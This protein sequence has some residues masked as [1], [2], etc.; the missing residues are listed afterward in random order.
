MSVS[1][2]LR[3]CIFCLQDR[4]GSQEHVFPRA[5]GGRLTIDRVCTSCNSMLGSRVDAALSDSFIVRSRRAQ[6]GLA[7]NSGEVPA[8]HE[9]LLG[10]S[11]LAD[12]PERRVQVAFNE[13]TGQLD[14]R[15][16]Y[17]ASDVVMPDGTKARQIIVDERDKD[18]IPKIIQRER[19][20]HGM[21]PLSEGQLAAEFTRL[22]QHV[23]AVENPRV[24]RELS[25][26]FAY[27]RH[28]ML[29]IAYEL[30]FLWLGEEYL[31][32]LDAVA[33]RTAICSADPTSTNALPAYVGDEGCDAFKFWSQ[34]KRHHLAYGFAATDG[35]AIAVRIFDAHAAVVWVTKDADKYLGGSDPWVKLRF[36]AIEP[37]SG[38][39]RDTP[40]LEELGRLA[41]ETVD[42]RRAAI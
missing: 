8:V 23:I 40:V 41:S 13:A 30:A 31:D 17:H 24:L 9:M 18:E 21:P 28:A 6:L 38:K 11:K 3:R 34:D 14:I 22:T 26:S 2:P 12:D 39:M 16:L 36:L 27:L 5:I 10:V 15:A 7:G 35:I 1:I 33:L 25:F 4:P 29:K 37:V 42:S 20:R 19:Q 32:D